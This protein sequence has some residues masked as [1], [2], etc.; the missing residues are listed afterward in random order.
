VL[1]ALLDEVAPGSLLVPL[2]V[3]LLDVL[4]PASYNHGLWHAVIFSL[5]FKG[6]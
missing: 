1:P 2:V 6:L 4:A 3:W 5:V